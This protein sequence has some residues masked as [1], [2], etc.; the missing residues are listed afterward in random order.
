L[1]SKDLWDSSKYNN[2]ARFEED[3]L[4]I[5]ELNLKI[6]DILYLYYD[7]MGN[8]DEDYVVE[9]EKYI[10]QLKDKEEEEKRKMKKE[11]DELESDIDSDFENSKK[12]KKKKKNN[13]SDSENSEEDSED[14]G[15][16]AKDDEE[17]RH[18]ST[19]CCNRPRRGD[20]REHQDDPRDQPQA[21]ELEGRPQPHH[22]LAQ[23]PDPSPRRC[24]H[25]QLCC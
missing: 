12:K 21:E 4:K 17:I 1:K 9:V 18:S 25:G 19:H 5:K 13:N 8:K 15:D 20:R 11:E 16:D 10:K 23:E 14:D 24:Q 6:K 2:T 7:L 22:S 3:L